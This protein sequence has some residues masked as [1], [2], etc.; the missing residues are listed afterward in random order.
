MLNE[1]EKYKNEDD[2]QRE[3]INS[4]NTFE[5]YVFQIKNTVNDDNVKEKFTESDKDTS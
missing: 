3:G 5:N 2:I 4:K 1:A